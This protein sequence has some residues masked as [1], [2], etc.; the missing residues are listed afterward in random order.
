MANHKSSQKRIRQTTRRTEVNRNRI[1]RI[2]TYVKRVDQAVAAGD[3]VAAQD[4]LK[5]AQAELMRGVS[6][7]VLKLAT[8]SRKVSRM[9]ARVKQIAS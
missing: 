2:R 4:A 7:G 5:V 3:K 8:V 9:S 1:S 6:K